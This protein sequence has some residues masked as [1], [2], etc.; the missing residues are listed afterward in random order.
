MTIPDWL[1]IIVIALFGIRQIVRHTNSIRKIDKTKKI[2]QEIDEMEKDLKTHAKK[3]ES[4]DTKS[5]VIQ[6]PNTHNEYRREKN[7]YRTIL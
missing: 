3:F 6:V 4:V 5:N 2:F 1:I 7:V